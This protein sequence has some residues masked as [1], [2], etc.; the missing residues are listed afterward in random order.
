MLIIRDEQMEIFEQA[1]LQSFED[2]MVEYLEEFFPKNCTLL[3]EEKVRQIIAQGWERAIQH[4]M[5]SERGVRIY[6]TLIFMLGNSFDSDPQFPWAEEI[7]KD[8]TI[9][10]MTRIDRLYAKAI[11]YIDHAMGVNNHSLNEALRRL[12]SEHIEDFPSPDTPEFYRSV[13]QRMTRIHPEKSEYIG[14]LNSRRLIQ[15]GVAS[16]NK[17]G[18]TDGRGAALYIGLMFM[19]GSGF[20]TDPHFQWAASILNEPRLT[21]QSSK[22][23]QLHQ[24][25]MAYLAQWLAPSVDAE[26]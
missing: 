25:A 1:A 20:D 22:T 26:V 13:I 17:Y 23:K 8:V 9:D 14:E 3:G 5:P 16:A 2:R 19:L 12:S 15:R 24:A 21:D 10:E 6:V 11:D 7:I 4:E 18:L